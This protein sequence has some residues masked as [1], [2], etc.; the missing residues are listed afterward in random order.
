LLISFFKADLRSEQSPV[1]EIK[2]VI[3][4]DVAGRSY[5]VVTDGRWWVDH[6]AGNLRTPAGWLES[7]TGG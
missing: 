4:P 6:I 2:P 3:A 1:L 5:I 7:L